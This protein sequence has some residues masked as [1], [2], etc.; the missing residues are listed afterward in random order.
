[1]GLVGCDSDDASS[2]DD[3]GSNAQQPGGTADNETDP[4]AQNPSGADLPDGKTLVFYSQDSAAQHSY[5]TDT[6]VAHDLNNDPTSNFY[7]RDKPMGRLFY[8]PDEYEPGQ[9]DE[10]VI[11]FRADYNY[12]SD[13]PVDHEDF[14]YL[15]HFHGDEL[16]A[17]SADEFDPED[18]SFSDG[19]QAALDR[20]NDYLAHRKELETEL[21][22]ALQEQAPDDALCAFL[23]PEHGPQAQSGH[24]HEEDPAHEAGEHGEDGHDEGG[25]DGE[26]HNDE[27]HT[28]ESAVPHYVLARSGRVFIFEDHE[29]GLEP[30]QSPVQLSGLSLCDAN[31]QG[32]L[33]LYG[34]HGILVFAEQS[35]RL[36]LVDEHGL[37]YHEHAM[38]NGPEF[39]P[40]GL[41]VTQMIGVD[42]PSGEDSHNHGEDSHDH[43]EDSHD[44]SEDSH[45]HSE[46]SHD[47]GE[48]SHDHE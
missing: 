44:H 39:L 24:G 22:T 36:Y 20:L 29:D 9:V 6:D 45:D 17:H 33:T 15:G 11:L 7:A 18:P 28:G 32:S 5:N 48:D 34:A 23:V 26:T 12:S 30:A 25:H 47:H 3:T 43:S 21:T 10:K 40:G 37:D 38:W 13:D 16:A 35:Q 31:N 42:N 1:L 41:A 27:N 19:K 4:N 46:D 2:S 8:W 14:L